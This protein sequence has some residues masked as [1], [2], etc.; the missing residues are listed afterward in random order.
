MTEEHLTAL[1]A[2][3]DAK[4]DD[5]GWTTASD[6]RTWTLYVASGAATL[7]VNK[8]EAVRIE[9]ELLRARTSKGELFILSLRDL[10]A[11]AVDAPTSSNRK[12]GFV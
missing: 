3:A 8:V 9:R 5:Q 7:T 10:F 4:K 2:A 6:G 1:L 12:A 11:G